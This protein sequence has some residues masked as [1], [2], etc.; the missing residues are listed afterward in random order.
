V[1]IL[2]G[3]DG[4]E[5]A[6]R[7]LEVAAHLA[8]GEGQVV[9]AN[10][11]PALQFGLPDPVWL[12]EQEPLLVEATAILREAGVAEPTTMSPLGEPVE[13]L[14]AAAKEAEADILVVGTHG[15]GAAGRFIVGSVS[16]GVARKAPCDVL[17]VP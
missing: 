8:G 5:A 3:Y 4:S 9:V 14:V 2:V 15:R 10:V 12:D 17:V 6:K 16:V 11:S 1:R 7:A 13:G